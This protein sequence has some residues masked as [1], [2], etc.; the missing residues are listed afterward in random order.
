MNWMKQKPFHTTE[1]GHLDNKKGCYFFSVLEASTSTL[2]KYFCFC[3]RTK[4]NTHPLTRRK[5]WSCLSLDVA[6]SRLMTLGGTHRG[7][8]SEALEPDTVDW[9]GLSS[10]KIHNITVRI[11]RIRFVRV[12]YQSKTK[13]FFLLQK[14][15]QNIINSRHG[16]GCVS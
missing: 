12:L 9:G 7:I 4:S 10:L 1:F 3:W 15:N 2:L 14:K 6:A 13:F 8:A 16:L 5:I 11:T